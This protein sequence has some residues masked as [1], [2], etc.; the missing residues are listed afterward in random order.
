MRFLCSELGLEVEEEALRRTVLRHAWEN[1]PWSRK[2]SG[3]FHRKAQP[4]GWREDLT[5]EQA[6][7]VEG[8]TSPILDRFYP[9]VPRH[10]PQGL[11]APRS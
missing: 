1:V 10:E 8:L 7:R 6:T 9:R 4:G 11:E 5:P 2:G 3:K